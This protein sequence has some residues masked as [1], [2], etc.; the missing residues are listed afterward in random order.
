M[1]TICRDV[2]SREHLHSVMLGFVFR[3]FDRG[4]ANTREQTG[5]VPMPW[6]VR[7]R[8]GTMRCCGSVGV[9][10]REVD[11]NATLL[12]NVLVEVSHACPCIRIYYMIWLANIHIYIH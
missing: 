3:H 7:N 9:V 6:V 2:L 12:V 11:R 8:C 1:M 4:G 10:S 5:I